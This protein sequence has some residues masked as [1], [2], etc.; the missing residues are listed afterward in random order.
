MKRIYH[1][2]L[3][4]TSTNN[5]VER[6]CH[7]C[8]RKVVFED[9][10]KRRHNANGKN[11]YEYAIFK[12]KNGHTW[13]RLL[14]I[15]KSKQLEDEEHSEEAECFQNV[16]SCGHLN[17]LELKNEGVNEI[18]IILDK[19][20]GRWRIDA[21]LGGRI[22]N[23]SRSKICE[24]IRNKKILLDGKAVKQNCI[25]KEEQTVTILLEGLFVSDTPVQ[26]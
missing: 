16:S 9:S 17:L 25:L 7:N 12:C 8:G 22:H 24:L 13:N 11:I 2:E 20:L 5:K 18:E 3:I 10:T 23:L 1:W 21:I 14:G 26:L 4:D 6:Y 15:S 19:V